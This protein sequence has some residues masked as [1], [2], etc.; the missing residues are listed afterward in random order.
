MQRTSLQMFF[1]KALES[2]SFELLHVYTQLTRINEIPDRTL[3][4]SLLK[5][6]IFQSIHCLK[7]GEGCNI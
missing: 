6:L 1:H 3:P 2:L 5:T 7:K 4:N